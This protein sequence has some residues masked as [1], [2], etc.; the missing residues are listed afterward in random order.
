MLGQEAHW[1]MLRACHA[2][3][4][5]ARRRG[6]QAATSHAWTESA[7]DFTRPLARSIAQAHPH[8]EISTLVC[9]FPWSTVEGK[10][11][12]RG[13]GFLVA[14]MNGK[15]A[16]ILLQKLNAQNDDFTKK[17]VLERS[18]TVDLARKV[19]ELRTVIHGLRRAK[20]DHGG[21]FASREVTKKT[22][23]EA[24]CVAD[25]SA[26]GAWLMGLCRR[27]VLWT[28][29]A[30]NSSCVCRVSTDTHPAVQELAVNVVPDSC[31]LSFT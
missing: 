31:A 2:C 4:K 16:T 21:A 23:K 24:R 15:A 25:V 10:S 5:R 1:S 6:H 18:R 20:K 17:I 11:R 30:A 7:S 12:H 14:A 3:R 13:S 27:A 19:E 29:R 9:R 26:A 22:S 8:M 28:L